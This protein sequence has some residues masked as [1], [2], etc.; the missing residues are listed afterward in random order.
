[1]RIRSETTPQQ[2][3][4]EYAGLPGGPM[5]STSLTMVAL[6]ALFAGCDKGDMVERQKA[7]LDTKRA[8][9][10]AEVDKVLNGWLDHMVETLPED[11]KKYPKVKSSLVDWRMKSLDYD[12]KRPLGAAIVKARGTPFLGEF[13]AI[14]QFFNQLELFWRKKIDFKD[15]MKFLSEFKQASDDPVANLL[16]DFDHTFVHLEAF[17][18]AQDMDGDDR[19]IYFFR[20][21]QVAFDFQ[22]EYHE[23]VSDYLARICKARLSDYCK[24]VPFEIMHFAMER[25]YLEVSNKIA[26]KFIEKY[27]KCRLKRVFMPYLDDIEARL[28]EIGPFE[29]FPKM[30]SSISKAPYVG[31]IMMMVSRK[32]IEYEGIDY[33]DFKTSW[34][35]S[36]AAWAKFESEMKS[37]QA[38]LEERRGPENLEVMVLSMDREAEMVIPARIVKIF[39][40]HPAR[41]VDFGGRRRLDGINRLTVSGRLEFREVPIA[42]RRL[43]IEGIGERACSPLGQSDDS[44]DLPSLVG[45]VVW[46]ENNE[47]FAGRLVENKVTGLEAVEVDEA[48]KRLS[49]GVGMLAVAADVN[50]SRFMEIFDPL[51]LACGDEA[52]QLVKER[53][54]RV[55]VQVCEG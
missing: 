45:N 13:E 12:W 20:H 24:T 30:P 25:P 27:D 7:A 42:P 28:P 46:L 11:V 52:C 50:Y 35:A 26:G 23:A 41:Y 1:M 4:R 36:G 10:A 31:N 34:A 49:D 44:E 32:G 40:E 51:F 15:Y 39:K 53:K 14:P 9:I 37:V 38:R 5:K 21:W 18:G 2:E 43:A 16:A 6:I 55:E 8:E 3:H 47:L 48:V 29:E 33:L 17:Y 19:A 22:R 54:P